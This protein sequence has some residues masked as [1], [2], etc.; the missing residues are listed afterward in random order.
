MVFKNSVVENIVVELGKFVLLIAL[1][2]FI[3]DELDISML[4]EVVRFCIS[5]LFAKSVFEYIL[6][7]FA[8]LVVFIFSVGVNVV[9]N[10]R[11]VESLYTCVEYIA[12]VLG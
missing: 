1:V 2:E 4:F 11:V 7:V 3:K 12:V 8:T 9:V 6:V 10:N 5:V